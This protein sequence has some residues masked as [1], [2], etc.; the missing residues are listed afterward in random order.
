MTPR[1]TSALAA[2]LF[3][4]QHAAWGQAASPSPIGSHSS[5]GILQLVIYFVLIVALLVAGLYLTRGGF[6]ALLRRGKGERKLV[7]PSALAYGPQGRPPIIPPNA[8]LNF[9]IE[10]IEV[11]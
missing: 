1:R 10:L 3:L 7:I 5:D 4:A 2:F 8:T 11:N 9:E 6:N